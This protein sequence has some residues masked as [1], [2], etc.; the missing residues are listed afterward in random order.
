MAGLVPAIHVFAASK[1][2][3]VDARHKAG[4]DDLKGKPYPFTSCFSDTF[5]GAALSPAIRTASPSAMP[6]GGVTTTR[7][8]GERPEASSMVRP[9]SRAM[10][11]FLNRILSSG[12]T[13]ATESPSLL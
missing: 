13:V 6:S 1:K 4:H 7:S 5:A 10:A 11:T 8:S 2:Q 9:R 12:P 3:D